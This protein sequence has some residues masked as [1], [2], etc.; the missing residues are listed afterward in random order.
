M[1]VGNSDGDFQMLAW[2]TA[3]E[4]PKRGWTIV[5]MARDWVVVF[6][7]DAQRGAADSHQDK[8]QGSLTIQ[9]TIIFILL[10]SLFVAVTPPMV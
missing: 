9:A 7:P 1:A 5:D 4:G 3:G 2:T 8:N 6:P 10:S